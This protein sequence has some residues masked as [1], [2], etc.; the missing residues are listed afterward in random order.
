MDAT[1]D[2][3]HGGVVAD[4]L[5]CF[6]FRG[7]KGRDRFLIVSGVA[8]GA[9]YLDVMRNLPLGGQRRGIYLRAVLGD[10]GDVTKIQSRRHAMKHD[11]GWAEGR[12]P[13]VRVNTE[14]L[15]CRIR[16]GE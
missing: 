1:Y 7:E 4:E 14:L 6:L 13:V 2:L 11:V 8:V 15:G 12:L 3:T 16:S 10:V 9:G 5:G